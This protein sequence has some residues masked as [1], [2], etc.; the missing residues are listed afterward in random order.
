MTFES[1]S[2]RID[3]HVHAGAMQLLSFETSPQQLE[4]LERE[5]GVEKA[6]VSSTRAIFYDMVTGNEETFAITRKSSMLYM[7]IYVDPLRLDE[8]LAEMEKYA[9]APHVAGIKT[10]P[11]YHKAAGDCEA[12]LAI[13]RRALKLEL[14]LL[15]HTFNLR[16]AA[17]CRRAA[18]ATGLK[19][20][21]AHMGAADWKATVDEV[22]GCRHVWLDACTSLNEYD[23]IGYALDTLGAS[24]L[25]FGTDSPFL[26]PWWTIGMFESAGL[27]EA[28]KHAVYRDNALGIFGKR[29]A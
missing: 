29:L 27:S 26:C 8:S 5:A 23:K 7:Y 19:M 2:R 24:Q 22:R 17:E 15:V 16:E 11:F 4:E 3:A 1:Q 18:E 28:E 9:H 12:Y 6:I 14:P 20:I 25:V 21:F 13:Y 10:R